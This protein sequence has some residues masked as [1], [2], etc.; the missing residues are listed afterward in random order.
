LGIGPGDLRKVAPALVDLAGISAS[1][2]S[3]A[4][5]AKMISAVV[6]R[7]METSYTEQDRQQM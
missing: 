6:E 4:E 1:E 7:D 3:P 2:H 5:I